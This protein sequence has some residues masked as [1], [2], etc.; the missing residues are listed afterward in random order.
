MSHTT[1]NTSATSIWHRKAL[2]SQ[3]PVLSGII[4]LSLYLSAP[5]T[6]LAEVMWPLLLAHLN[7]KYWGLNVFLLLLCVC[8]CVGG[9]VQTSL[10]AEIYYTKVNAIWIDPL[11]I[12]LYNFTH[13]SNNK[14]AMFKCLTTETTQWTASGIIS[15]YVEMMLSALLWEVQ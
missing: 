6:C 4:K 9:C 13:L 10:G 15:Y 8:V 2:R 7:V 14:Y 3:N 5:K 12:T 11:Q 1:T